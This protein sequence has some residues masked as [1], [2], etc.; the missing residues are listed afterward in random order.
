[1]HLQYFL[2]GITFCPKIRYNGSYSSTLDILS[3][4]PQE[5]ILGPLLFS[6]CTSDIWKNID[7]CEVQAFTDDTQLDTI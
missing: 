5:S 1:M 4:V 7:Q 6:V 3:G 2:Y